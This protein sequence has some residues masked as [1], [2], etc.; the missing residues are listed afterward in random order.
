MRIR[1]LLA[2]WLLVCAVALLL[3]PAVAQVAPAGGPGAT[4][5]PVAIRVELGWQ[6]QVVPGCTAPAVIYLTNKGEDEL[7]GVV[8]VV[9]YLRYQ[10]QEPPGTQPEASTQ[11]PA[12]GGVKY[13]PDAAFGRDVTLPPGSAKKVVLWFPLSTQDGKLAFRFRVGARVLVTTAVM[14]PSRPWQHPPAYRVGILG[15]VPPALEQVRFDA[16]NGTRQ[17]PLLLRLTPELFPQTGDELNACGTILVTGNGS[18]GLTSRQRLALLEWVENG[19]RLMLGGGISFNKMFAGLLS[20]G[21]GRSASQPVDFVPFAPLEGQGT[22]WASGELP[23]AKRAELGYGTITVLGFDPNRDPWR[24]GEQGRNFWEKI[25]GERDLDNASN[26]WQDILKSFWSFTDNLPREAFPGLPFIGLYLGAFIVVAGPLVFLVLRRRERPGYAWIAVP[27][28]ALLFAGAAYLYMIA[29]GRNV[30]V[31]TVQVLDATVPHARLYTAVGFFAPTKPVFD[32]AMTDPDRP[33]QVRSSGGLPLEL[34]VARP[35]PDYS[36]IRSGKLLRIRFNDTSQWGIRAVTYHN[37]VRDLSGLSA[38]LRLADSRLYGTVRNDT[39]ISFDHVTL[40]LG[41]DYKVLGNLRPGE[42]IAFNMV[43]PSLPSY[44]PSGYPEKFYPRSWEIF[45]YPG[46]RPD[47]PEQEDI[48]KMIR[49]RRPLT[50]AEQRRVMM[51]ENWLNGLVGHGP[52]SEQAGYPL[53]LVA[54]SE[55]PLQP[56]GFQ[57]L[58][59]KTNYLSMI[60]KRPEIDLPKGSFQVPGG[61]VVPELVDSK[62]S[63]AWHDKLLGLEQGYVT[64][65]FRP[66]F[67][68]TAVH[69]QRIRLYLSVYPTARPGGIGIPAEAAAVPP[70]VLE[71]YHPGRGDWEELTGLKEFV[72]GGDY[73]LPGGEVRV[74]I[75]VPGDQP[76]NQIYFLP[77]AVAYEG[78][79]DC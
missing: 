11:G 9:N 57:G 17:A 71:I 7:A 67:F 4:E 10:L 24:T 52:A 41:G 27:L 18:N 72:L 61:L 75:R 2:K 74:R 44:D 48:A 42:E 34:R 14:M 59:G 46:G 51:L 69:I 65:A 35:E 29:T 31:N 62:A 50:V 53:S 58:K 64:Y 32:V 26:R 40:L 13:I 54:W 25:L 43:L 63:F 68:Q 23:E 47:Q 30:L 28:L 73:A 79:R 16:S 37:N 56:A 15:E 78:V 66:G 76:G 55:D 8:D 36:L 22:R 5:N 33:V 45:Y 6:E 60:L 49:K 38:K 1:K 20:T 12:S 19:G 77:P 39:E 21:A 3:L 70:G